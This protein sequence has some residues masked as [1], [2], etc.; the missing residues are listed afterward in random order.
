MGVSRPDGA[1]PFV[2]YGMRPLAWSV[3]YDQRRA[4]NLLMLIG[5]VTVV[6]ASLAC[7]GGEEDHVLL[8]WQ[9]R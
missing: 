6:L 1:A 5:V 4:T 2:V 3:T 8:G 9:L 7:G